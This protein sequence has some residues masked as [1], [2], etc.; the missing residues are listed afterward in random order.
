MTQLCNTGYYGPMCSLCVKDPTLVNGRIVTYG[1]TGPL[2][3]QPC[4]SSAL[5]VLAYIVSSV[6]VLLWLSYTVHVTLHDNEAAAR[7]DP[8]P[9]RTAQPPGLALHLFH[10]YAFEPQSLIEVICC[11]ACLNLLLSAAAV[12]FANI[13]CL[14]PV[15]K[16]SVVI[17]F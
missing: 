5:I 15:T 1:R 16:V 8:D 17:K 7:G 4:R 14:P 10:S 2:K 6:V 12:S 13:V 9:G 3:C 11:I